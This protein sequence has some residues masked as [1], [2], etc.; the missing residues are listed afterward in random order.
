[1]GQGTRQS[2][3]MKFL[4]DTNI[5]L[6]LEPV[7]PQGVV[8]EASQTMELARLV[9]ASGNQLLI[10]PAVRDDIA[11]DTDAARRQVREHVLAKYSKLDDPPAVTGGHQVAL[12]SP[13][14][15]SNDWVDN[16]LLVAVDRHAVE[17]LVTQDQGIHRKAARLGIAPRVLTVTGALTMLRA[18]FDTT[19]QPPPAVHE[20]KLY[21][22]DERDPIFDGFRAD[23]PGFDNWLKGAK[24]DGRP[25]WAI[26]ASDR[27]AAICIVKRETAPC[28]GMQGKILKIS[29]FKVADAFLGARY[30]ELLLK[31]VFL[32]ARQNHFDWLYVTA[33][34]KHALLVTMLQDFGF[35]IRE[36]RTKLGELVLTKR[37]EVIDAAAENLPA[38]EYTI[39]YGPCRLKWDG[40]GGWIVP[41]Q[42]RYEALLFPEKQQQANLFA[43][44]QAFGNSIR[45]AY[46]CLSQAKNLRP[47]QVLAFYRSQDEKAIRT[48]GVVED[49]QRSNS[50]EDL[51]TFVA[52]RTVYSMAEIRGMCSRTRPV[53]AI[54]FRQALMEFDPITLEEL[55][56]GGVL[57]GPPQSLTSVDEERMT[58]LK[59]RIA[60]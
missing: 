16:Q 45:K 30:G 7:T 19:P 27:L 17:Y 9:Q 28:Y 47:G 55:L 53:L 54:L 59:Q 32:Y 40:I 38:L 42:P 56:Q 12:G 48:L 2:C 29:S 35:E 39:K 14:A 43:G 34:E 15:G 41:I 6:P 5:L 57:N 21:N 49:I 37:W 50:A 22:V 24:L 13:P 4:I 23:Y 46:L 58:W 31:T 60:R 8:P 51:S 18:L 44:Q 1:M 52:R 3:S 36:E 26:K 20:I 33:F 11:R 10:H 25:A